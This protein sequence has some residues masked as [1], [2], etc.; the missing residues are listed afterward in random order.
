MVASPESITTI[1]SVSLDR[2]LISVA[3]MTNTIIM[4]A[5]QRSAYGTLRVDSCDGSPVGPGDDAE[6]VSMAGQADGGEH[7]FHGP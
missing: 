7:A 6:F 4:S 1:I 3:T 2:W 5:A